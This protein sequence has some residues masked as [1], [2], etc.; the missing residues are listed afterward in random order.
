VDSGP[1]YCAGMMK[2]GRGERSATWRAGCARGPGRG[3]AMFSLW[4]NRPSIRVRRRS[5]IP[6]RHRTPV[7]RRRGATF[8]EPRNERPPMVKL[9]VP[10]ASQDGRLEVMSQVSRAAGPVD[11]KI[12]ASSGGSGLVKS[13][14]VRVEGTEGLEWIADRLTKSCHTGASLVFTARVILQ[15]HSSS[16]CRRTNDQAR[17]TDCYFRPAPGPLLRAHTATTS[18]ASM[19]VARFKSLEKDGLSSAMVGRNLTSRCRRMANRLTPRWL[20]GLC[21]IGSRS[22][23]HTSLLA[24]TP[25]PNNRPPMRLS[26]DEELFLRHWMYDEVHYQDGPGPA[27]RLQLQHRA[28]PADLATLIAAAI[29]DFADQEM[30]GLSRPSA[31]TPRWPWTEDS[32]SARLSEARTALVERSAQG[33]PM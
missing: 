27:K 3:D 31:A 25:M 22:L 11:N 6:R 17:R 32:L 20:T 28:I 10:F 4:R 24:A 7:A 2:S 23:A 9:I 21:G 12:V 19:I 13:F 1:G 29:P 33:S 8:V 15:T 14:V 26:P 16:V 18:S 30:A 5:L